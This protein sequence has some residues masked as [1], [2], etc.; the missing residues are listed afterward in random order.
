MT[1]IK[2]PKSGSFLGAYLLAK[3]PKALVYALRAK[4]ILQAAR[5]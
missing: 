5:L 1:G 2:P 4:L 3:Q